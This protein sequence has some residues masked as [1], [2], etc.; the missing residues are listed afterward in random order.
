MQP[1]S[2]RP[3]KLGLDAVPLQTLNGGIGYFIFHLADALISAQPKWTFYL[4]SFSS[5][6]DIAHFK[7]YPNVI[8]R[9]L[10]FARQSHSL[11][12]QTTLPYGLYKDHIDVFW[13]T[14]QS[15]P[16][17]CRRKIKTLLLIHDFVFHF[18]PET[19]ST[20]KCIYFKTLTQSMV[21]KA[22]LILANSQA[23][24]DKLF[25]LYA[26]K[27]DFILHP[28]LKSAI[29]YQPKESSE[30]F[31]S[32][33]S[34]EHKK[35]F[36]TIGTLEPRKNFIGLLN[37]YLDLLKRQKTLF[38]LVIVGSGGWKNGAIVEKLKN[39]CAA[40]PDKILLLGHIGDEAL[41]H[42]LSGARFYLCFSLYEGYGMPLAEA[43]H[44]RT[45]VICFD[46]S[47]MREAAENDGIFLPSTGFEEKLAETLLLQDP[48]IP[49]SCLY[50]ST[51]EKARAFSQAV[52]D[53]IDH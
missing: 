33:L 20:L 12:S 50:T 8:I 48:P 5:K 32:S 22:D 36:L 34:L 1:L 19:V 23:T 40:F 52:L 7:K 47:E 27:S 18:F 21:R 11:W 51:E 4:Y 15:I 38:P 9:P 41:S 14:T 30:K 26:R 16:L 39:A 6:G 3:L 24:A 29:Q 17:F 45:P 42:L 2:S 13:G 43:R 28:P 44:C 35:Y 37:T 25:A 31:L 53:L 10:P 49:S 46:Q